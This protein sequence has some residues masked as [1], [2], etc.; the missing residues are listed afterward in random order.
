MASAGGEG[1]LSVL[2][3]VLMTSLQ[4]ALNASSL[5]QQVYANNI[6]NA[7]TPGFKEQSVHFNRLLQA[8]LK[9]V[10]V[11]ASGAL[12]MAANSPLD[13][14]GVLSSPHSVNPVV[15]TDSATAVSSTGNNVNLGAQMSKLAENQL[16]YAALV[17]ELNY[18]FAMLRTAILGS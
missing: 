13:L 9:Q 12:T 17:Q 10:G 1:A 14:S 11:G 2:D 18:Q 6:A 5:R 15:V 3:S 7:Q 8:Q 16:Q 4:S